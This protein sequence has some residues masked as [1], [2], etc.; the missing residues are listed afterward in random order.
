MI[1][2]EHPNLPGGSVRVEQRGAGDAGFVSG[3]CSVIWPG[4]PSLARYLCDH[5]ELVRGRRAVELGAG[6]GLVGAAAAALGASCSVITDCGA[7]LPLLERNRELLAK[8][9]IKVEAAQVEWGSDEDHA[10]I[11]AAD[12]GEGP[13]AFDVVLASDVIIAGFYTDRL[14]R[15]VM[16]LLS[17]DKDAKVILAFEF[18]EDWETIGTFVGWM[19]EAGLAVSHQTLPERKDSEEGDS[20]DDSD[21]LLYTFWWPSPA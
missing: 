18:R 5:P 4:A 2:V 8:D 19:E 16:A 17:R 7:A 13:A 11:L 12:T 9:G 14:F 20:D 15:S 6:I 3:T 21:M 1:E 10:A